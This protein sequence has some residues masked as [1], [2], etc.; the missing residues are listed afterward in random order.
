MVFVGDVDGM[1]GGG[2]VVFGDGVRWRSGI[3]E[4]DVEVSGGGDSEWE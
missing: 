3:G 1:G 2:V 4:G